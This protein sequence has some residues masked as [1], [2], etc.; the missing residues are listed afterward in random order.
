MSFPQ[1]HEMEKT[2]EEKHR[3]HF[4]DIAEFDKYPCGLS[5]TLTQDEINKLD[6][7]DNPDVGD[8]VHLCALAKVISVSKDDREH[9]CETRVSLQITHLGLE[10]GD[11]DG[12]CHDDGGE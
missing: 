9:G 11:D 10:D 12:D 6:L 2:E 4:G 7:D 8:I 5:I 3:S 1:L